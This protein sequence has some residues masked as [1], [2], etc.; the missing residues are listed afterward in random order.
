M[1]AKLGT[2]DAR[3]YRERL[4]GQGRRMIGH[5]LARP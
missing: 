2:F 5:L 3:A 1:L 4:K